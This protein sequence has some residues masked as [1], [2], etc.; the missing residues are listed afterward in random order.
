M[1]TNQPVTEETLARM[2]V[3]YEQDKETCRDIARREGLHHITV[4]KKLRAA[5]VLVEPAGRRRK[6]TFTA[7]EEKLM[8][9]WS[10]A[11]VPIGEMARRLKAGPSVVGRALR[12]L[13]IVTWRT[14]DRTANWKGGRVS[15]E[16]G[17]VDVWVA[18]DDPMAVMR[19]R[20]GY[21]GE[22]RLVMAR[23]LG[24]P[25]TRGET[26]HHKNGVHDDNREGNLQLRRG[27][28]GKHQA[29][30]CRACGSHDVEAVAVGG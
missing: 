30:Q 24:R 6:R 26:V 3:A 2:V 11:A 25:L 4:G 27:K 10:E 19:K 16:G 8:L 21:V 7:D 9:A 23:K 29:F 1:P 17:Y 5:G 12:A 18:A 13:G 28:H 22:H 14:G 20:S 15:V